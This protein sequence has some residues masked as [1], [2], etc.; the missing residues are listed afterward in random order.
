[1][2]FSVGACAAHSLAFSDKGI[3]F[4]VIKITV[5]VNSSIDF[6]AI[7]IIASTAVHSAMNAK[8]EGIKCS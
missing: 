1:M 5:Y 6:I 8:T 4:I 2:L 3:Y 7:R